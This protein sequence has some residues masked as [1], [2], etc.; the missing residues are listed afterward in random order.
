MI[1]PTDPRMFHPHVER[2][3]EP[4]L[5][6]LKRLLPARA[7]VL[8][9]ASGSGEHA[10]YFA[11][12]LPRASWLPSDIDPRAWPVSPPF[13]PTRRCLICLPPVRF[14]ATAETWPV[15]RL[16]AIV[17]CNMI[18]IAP[19]AAAQGVIA[20][21]GR[22]LQSGRVLVSLWA[23][24]DRWPAHGAE[25]S[26][27]RYLAART[28][29]AMGRARSRRRAHACG[30]T[31]A[32][33]WPKPCRCRPTISASSFG[34][35]DRSRFFAAL[36]IPASAAAVIFQ[37]AGSTISQTRHAEEHDSG[38]AAMETCDDG[39]DSGD[40]APS[41][42]DV[43]KFGTAAALATAAGPVL[44]ANADTV[45]GVVYENRSGGMHRTRTIRALPAC[46][47]RTAAR[48]RKPMPTAATRCRSMTKAS[49]SSSSPRAMRCRSTNR[50]CRASTTFISRQVRRRT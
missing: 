17:C 15:K 11:K 13:G 39:V 45:S 26:G 21:A 30:R 8:E 18:H 24:Q 25:Q 12:G 9:V 50:C 1:E 20:G 46:W 43:M 41:R 49:S 47:S 28:K 44:A 23:V 10:A 19:W 38:D 34:G 27:L 4:I 22:V 32:D 14:D 48:W 31:W 16:N 36:V 37:S 33:A 7:L 42:R 35:P 6:V 40:W 3:R 5:A 29:S 2:N